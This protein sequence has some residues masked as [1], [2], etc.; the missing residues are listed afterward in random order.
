MTELAVTTCAG[1]ACFR[2]GV[3]LAHIRLVGGRSV[4]LE[5]QVHTTFVDAASFRLTRGH[6]VSYGLQVRSGQGGY[7]LAGATCPSETL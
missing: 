6:N 2:S 3:C 1:C 5:G 4:L 7:G